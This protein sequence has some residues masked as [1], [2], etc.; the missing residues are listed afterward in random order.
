MS[1]KAS[2]EPE[3]PNIV[4]EQEQERV[5]YELITGHYRTDGKFVTTDQV[6]TEYV[7][8]TDEM[9]H[10]ATHGVDV[11]DPDTSEKHKEKVDYFVWLDKSSR[12]VAWLTRDL[13]PL[14]AEEA[15]GSVPK[16]PE[17]KFVN[18]DRNQWTSDIDPD[19]QGHTDVS[20]L[21]PNIIRSLRSIFLANP[22][23]RKEGLTEKID[24]APSIFD[25]K[26]VLIVDELR[27]SGRTLEYA[28]RFFER[29]FPEAKIA[30]TYWMSGLTTKGTAVGNADAPVWYSDATEKGR[31]IGN[32][33][34]DLSG[35]SKNPT[36]RLGAWFLST[37][38]NQPDSL[39][40]SLR[41]EL[42]QLAKDA[43]EGKILVVPSFKREDADFDERA[44]RL[45]KLEKYNEFI[46][47]KRKL[48][49]QKP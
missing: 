16:M 28:K 7:R 26:T 38:L 29:A 30:G 4:P 42:H 11:L 3:Q 43:K 40:V 9:V 36:Q 10:K 44:M 15:D 33:N 45:N 1:E 2:H 12:P 18:I 35:A 46:T 5:P 27:S 49:T 47:K 39:S 22:K 14:L 32:R 20:K 23:D 21:S 37:A 24:L 31:G 48:D 41:A 8:L 25:G 19:G 17:S 13:W 6:H 34:I